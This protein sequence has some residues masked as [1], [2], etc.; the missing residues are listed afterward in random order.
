MLFRSHTAQ[1]GARR[2]QVEQ[3]NAQRAMLEA[4]KAKA[5]KKGDKEAVRLAVQ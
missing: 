1:N 5:I 4:E 2:I 3:S